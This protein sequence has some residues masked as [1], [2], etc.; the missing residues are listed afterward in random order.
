MQKAEVITIANQKG[1]VGKTTTTLNLGYSL[2]E[3]GKKVLLID[4]DSQANLTTCLGIEDHRSIEKNIAHLM[5]DRMND[6]E[7]GDD[8][9]FIQSKDGLDFIPS[10]IALSV[11]DV[12]LKM[13][14]GSE[15]ILSEIIEPLREKYDYIIIDTCP[16]LG[17]LT[18][19]ALCASDS[20]I[21][22]VN[23]QMLA[24][25]G[26]NDFIKTTMK[27]KKRLNSKLEIKGI[28][29]TM[30]DERTVL[31]QVAILDIEENY[32]K[33]IKIYKNHIPMNVKIGEAIYSS[34]S[35][36]EYEPKAKGSIA[37]FNFAKE[38]ANGDNE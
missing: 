4:F 13:E 19:N 2:K 20:V 28:L 32:G 38:V 8:L 1:G 31:S 6:E 11:I 27:I 14:L 3:M 33:H 37:Y 21:I 7:I 26:L 10:S 16:S 30:C 29:L 9:S 12:N 17:S 23:P 24:I 15:K 18:T 34:Q 22:P 25:M 36:M 35:V 5:D